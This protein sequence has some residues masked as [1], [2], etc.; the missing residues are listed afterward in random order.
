MRVFDG[1]PECLSWISN[2]KEKC[3][4]GVLHPEGGILETTCISGEKHPSDTE[5][6]NLLRAAKNFSIETEEPAFLGMSIGKNIIPLAEYN[7]GKL[8][9]FCRPPWRKGR[10]L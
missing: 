7:A 6:E 8:V 1:D 4:I 2:Q 3:S 10:S 9:A 5:F